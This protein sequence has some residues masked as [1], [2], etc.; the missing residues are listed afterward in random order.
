M[1]LF[2][3]ELFQ[4][5]NPPVS[6]VLPIFKGK[7]SQNY[8]RL[9]SELEKQ[10]F[11][12]FEVIVSC[13]VEPNG[14]ARNEAVKEAQGE[15]LVFIDE[16]TSLE[17]PS[18]IEK[19]VKPLRENPQASATGVAVKLHPSAN[20]IQ[21]QYYYLTRS[22]ETASV[23]ELTESDQVQHACMAIKTQVFKTLGGESNVLITGT[24]N[25][26]RQR[27]HEKGYRLFLVPDAVIYHLP[28][29]SL[30]KIWRKGIQKGK[31]SAFAFL[32]FPGLFEFASLAGYSIR[33]PVL[34]LIYKK[35]SILAK[36]LHPKY[37]FYPVALLYEWAIAL[38]FIAGWFQWIGKKPYETKTRTD[39]ET[40]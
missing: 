37:W 29:S 16:T 11:K 28:P 21:K 7:A 14:R 17:D 2:K 38:G 39:L 20:S 4:K 26:L 22:F 5:K 40:F 36:T 8:H 30:G 13:N 9:L 27:M 32:M 1:K 10:T 35:L 31:G 3:P 33:N 34:G 23:K 19:L 25:D 6:V 15:I 24:D 12:D 18:L